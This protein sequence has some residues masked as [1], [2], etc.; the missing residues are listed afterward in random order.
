MKAITIITTV[1][2]LPL[3]ALRA[4]D[5][6]PTTTQKSAARVAFAQSCFWTGE[7]RL[8]QIEGVVRTEAG[9]FQAREV[10]L[11]DFDP[12]RI[13][14]EQLAA[15]AR[16]AGVA[17][18]IY[19]PAGSHLVGATVAGVIVGAPLDRTY[20][21]ASASDQKKQLE[22][23]PYARLKLTPEQATKVNAFARVDPA[24]A[25]E[26]LTAVQRDNLASAR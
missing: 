22:G 11:V 1:V 16:Q 25:N 14:L 8:G 9:Y 17:D 15:Q 21:T 3:A 26:W 24:K 19:L 7:M 6:E 2:L 5:P 18:G 10:T 12:S 4:E 23:T 20:R 13:S